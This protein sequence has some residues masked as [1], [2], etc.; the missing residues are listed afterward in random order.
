MGVSRGVG[1]E[2]ENEEKEVNKEGEKERSAARSSVFFS[3][4]K[5]VE[6]PSPLLSLSF[7]QS[8]N[9][10][11]GRRGFGTGRKEKKGFLSSSSGWIEPA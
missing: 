1:G 11:G 5:G 10:L 9:G 8:S 6:E 3:S 7:R 2:G 4:E